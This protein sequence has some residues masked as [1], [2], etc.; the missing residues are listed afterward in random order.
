MANESDVITMWRELF[1]GRQVTGDTLT[2]ADALIDRLGL[3]SPL[4]L[5]LSRELE[6]IR[7]LKQHC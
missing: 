4:R 6:E 2:K 5:R 1:R 7:K 3:E